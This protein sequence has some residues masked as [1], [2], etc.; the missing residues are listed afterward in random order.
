MKLEKALWDMEK[1]CNGLG[2]YGEGR[3]ILDVARHFLEGTY[4]GISVELKKALSNL[5]VKGQYVVSRTFNFL[6]KCKDH[7]VKSCHIFI[8]VI[9]QF[10]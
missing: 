10:N 3:N 5:H 8:Y 1:T 2:K 6:K 4:S 7:L 9:V